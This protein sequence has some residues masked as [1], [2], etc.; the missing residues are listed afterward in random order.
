MTFDVEFI[1]TLLP[2]DHLWL[3]ETDSP[4]PSQ[5]EPSKINDSKSNPQGPVR[6]K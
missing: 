1:K 4:A 2:S 3:I 5:E 6:V